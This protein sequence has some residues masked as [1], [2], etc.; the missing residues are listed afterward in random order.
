VVDKE[1]GLSRSSCLGGLRFFQGSSRS[2]SGLG[3]ACGFGMTIGACAL[4]QGLATTM[5]RDLGAGF[6]AAAA[7]GLA[8]GGTP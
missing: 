7:G 2:S 8:V 5:G 6:G 1:L 4:S 3:A